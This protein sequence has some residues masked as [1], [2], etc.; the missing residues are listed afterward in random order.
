MNKTLTTFVLVLETTLGSIVIAAVL[1]SP[2]HWTLKVAFCCAFVLFT[3]LR[4]LENVQSTIYFEQICA[5]IGLATKSLEARAGGQAAES[6]EAAVARHLREQQLMDVMGGGGRAHVVVLLGK[7]GLWLGLGSVLAA[8]V[9]PGLLS[10][11]T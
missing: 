2:L 10:R 11:Y 7:Y 6:F 8:F 9:A 5:L 4:D 1:V 3:A